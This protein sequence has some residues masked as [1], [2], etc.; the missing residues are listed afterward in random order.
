M[1]KDVR[2]IVKLLREYRKNI[3]VISI[4]MLLISI[5]SIISPLVTQRMIDLGLLEGNLL[6]T[7]K[8]V[9]YLLAIFAL[10]Q[11]IVGIQFLDYAKISIGLPFQL[12]L[13]ASLHILKIRIK[14]FK[15]KNFST[16]ISELFQDISNI[17]SLA[18]SNLLSSFVKLFEIVAGVIALCLISWKLTLV[19]LAVIPIRLLCSKFLF[20]KEQ[21]IFYDIMSNQSQFSS[22]LGDSISGVNEI[23]LWGLE[24]EKIDS[25][26]NILLEGNQYKKRLLC[27]KQIDTMLSAIFT[28]LVTFVLYC[29]GSYLIG[30]GELTMGGL[31][32]FIAYSTLVTEPIT[33]IAYLI[34]QISSI[35]PAI[36]R[37][38]NFMNTEMEKDQVEDVISNIESSI[39]QISFEHV[40]FSYDESGNDGYRLKDINFVI[41]KGE[42]VAI[43]GKNGSGKSSLINLLLRF[44]NQS[45]GKILINGKDIT[46]IE[47]RKY[48]SLFS[49]ML[50]SYYLF[51]DTVT[52]NIDMH[53]NLEEQEIIE[54]CKRASAVNDIRKLKDK[55]ATVVGYNGAKLSGGQRQ[56]IAL[57]RTLAKKNTQILILDEATSNFDYYSENF[58]N[59][60]ILKDSSYSIKIV[61]THRPEIL[62]NMDKIVYLSDGKIV[63]VGKFEDIY[64]CYSEFRELVTNNEGG[65]ENAI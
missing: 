55:F 42:R 3:I 25:L 13:D 19:I 44:Y 49:C 31:M 20:H 18:D 47:L 23:R 52:N 46:S 65:M 1:K 16:V 61:I 62:K 56:K 48:R 64:R 59:N 8:Y 58:I 6:L 32:A 26:R 24:E 34:T 45:E 29:V 54:Y 11:C 5:G 7:I 17:S 30:L 15:E 43:I 39:E 38:Q 53:H 63:D 12:N 27:F 4:S 50:Q 21:A 41:N 9:G 35:L 28:T 33:I 57:A 60:M 22:W 2:M 14:Y 10:Q 40:N 51:N 37:F 36:T